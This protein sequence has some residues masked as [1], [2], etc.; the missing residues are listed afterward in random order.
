MAPPFLLKLLPTG[1]SLVFHG[2][3][4]RAEDCA[5]RRAFLPAITSPV[6]APMAAPFIL[7]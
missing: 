5:D 2:L 4:L 6:T 1:L 3:P 7:L